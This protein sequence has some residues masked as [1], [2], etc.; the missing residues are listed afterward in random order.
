MSY[1]VAQVTTVT[2]WYINSILNPIIYFC[3]NKQTQK[4]LAGSL[5]I[6]KMVD[7]FL[8][9]IYKIVDFDYLLELNTEQSFGLQPFFPF[10]IIV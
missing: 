9:F 10:R 2:F 7:S 8:F 3:M 5:I 1:E 4:N 6:F